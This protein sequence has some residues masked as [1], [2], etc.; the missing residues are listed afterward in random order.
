MYADLLLLLVT[1]VE[2][3][4]WLLVCRDLPGN[5]KLPQGLV[6]GFDDGTSDAFLSIACLTTAWLCLPSFLSAD[7]MWPN[8][9]DTTVQQVL[10]FKHIAKCQSHAGHM[11]VIPCS[12]L[13]Q[14]KAAP[15]VFSVCSAHLL[16][17]EWDGAAGLAGTSASMA[18]TA[19][20]HVLIAPIESFV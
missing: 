14:H 16:P 3:R 11:P 9:G 1:T 10:R 2:V 13:L 17:A 18:Y 8:S 19:P 20:V 6:T 4:Q 15:S 5:T 7:M 12:E